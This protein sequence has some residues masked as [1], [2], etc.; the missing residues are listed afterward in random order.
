MATIDI[1]P[2][3]PS[4]PSTSHLSALAAAIEADPARVFAELADE[5]LELTSRAPSQELWRFWL[6]QYETLV[7]EAREYAAPKL[8]ESK[9][10]Q[11]RRWFR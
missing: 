8:A 1:P 4:A 9:P 6:D 2:P 10:K 5:A 11:R 3:E 7:Y